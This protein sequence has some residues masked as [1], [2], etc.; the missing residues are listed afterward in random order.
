MIIMPES[1]DKLNKTIAYDLLYR[2]VNIEQFW[3]LFKTLYY[4]SRTDI[5]DL[6]EEFFTNYD[7]TL[8]D[9]FKF[10]RKKLGNILDEVFSF[11]F[12]MIKIYKNKDEMFDTITEF[13]IKNHDNY[14][15][16]KEVMKDGKIKALYNILIDISDPIL[17]HTKNII[18]GNDEFLEMF[19][20]IIEDTDSLILGTE[21]LKKI[22]D[23]NFIKEKMVGFLSR[24]VNANTLLIK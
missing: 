3:E 16:I 18:L 21:M 20:N 4:E 6:V 9:V 13:L 11:I 17:N 5:L 23:F 24:I 19:L 2:L 15:K 14:D 8:A 22:N 12:N 7:S 10:L 1:E